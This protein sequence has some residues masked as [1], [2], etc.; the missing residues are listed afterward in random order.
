MRQPQRAR[1]G[2]QITPERGKGFARGR[3]HRLERRA[4][5]RR[6]KQ[7]FIQR[8]VPLAPRAQ[9]I[10]LPLDAVQRRRQRDR[11]RLPR[12]KFGAIRAFAHRAVRVI[13]EIANRAHRQSF[14]FAVQFN[15]HHDLRRDIAVQARPRAP[16]RK[17]HF[18]GEFFF[19]RRHLVRGFDLRAP[20]RVL[21]R[22]RRF[23]LR[24]QRVN[25]Q[26]A[27]P[28]REPRA[29]FRQ[30]D[31]LHLQRAPFR[32]RQR[33][34]RIGRHERLN[35]RVKRLHLVKRRVIGGHRRIKR[36]RGCLVGHRVG[37]AA[38]RVL[39][40]QLR[41]RIHAFHRARKPL[42]EFIRSE[43]G[44]NIGHVPVR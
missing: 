35:V 7:C 39:V 14:R 5:N 12:V 3:Q 6:V 25:V 10:H 11:M 42:L 20:Q 30:R 16:A 21:V 13:R 44:E 19:D 33:V 22:P 18:R 43:R 24:E 15:V 17:I 32:L 40:K 31:E 41:E 4:V 36:V 2:A 28:R 34:A 9:C 1:F 38:H 29:E 27:D 26:R 23:G 8:A 37:I